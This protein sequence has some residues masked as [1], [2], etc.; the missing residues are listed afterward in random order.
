[1]KKAGAG[2]KAAGISDATVQQRTGKSWKE[3]FS[4]LD[5][6]GGKKKTHRELV[7]FLNQRYPRLGGWWEQMITVAYE[8]ARGLR[9]P[10]QQ[11]SGFT[12]NVSKTIAAPLARLYRAWTQGSY[13]GR[14]LPEKNFAV[15][16]ATRNKSLRVTWDAGKSNLEVNFYSKGAG[17][18][19][20]VVQHTHLPDARA[21]ARA[22]SFWSGRLGAL[23]TYLEK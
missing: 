21:V 20:V 9:Q 22:K 7:I 14:W 3:W 2:K 18:S 5:H 1:M 16:K 6:F 19:Q 8:Q 11:A 17:K 23:K 13:R 4:I 12:A 15:R 10:H